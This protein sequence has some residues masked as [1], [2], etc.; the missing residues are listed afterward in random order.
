LETIKKI[1]YLSQPIITLVSG[2]LILAFSFILLR[3]WFSV[4]LV[5][6]SEF[7][8]NGIGMDLSKYCNMQIEFSNYFSGWRNSGDIPL[9]IIF[10]GSTFLFI[11]R[12]REKEQLSMLPLEFGVLNILFLALGTALFICGLIV[13]LFVSTGIGLVSG[14][15]GFLLLGCKT[16]AGF[17]PGLIASI[18]TTAGLFVSQANGWLGRLLIRL[19]PQYLKY[20]PLDKAENKEET[21]H[22]QVI[23]GGGMFLLLASILLLYTWL[24]LFFV[25]ATSRGGSICWGTSCEQAAWQDGLSRSLGHSFSYSSVPYMPFLLIF[26]ITLIIFMIR[27]RKMNSRSFLALEFGMLN[28]LWMLAGMA[29]FTLTYT[30]YK[31]ATPAPQYPITIPLITPDENPAY[32]SDTT[33]AEIPYLV[34][35]APPAP[36]SG[37]CVIADETGWSVFD[38]ADRRCLIASQIPSWVYGK[39]L[40]WSGLLASI[41]LVTGLSI[42]QATGWLNRWIRRWPDMLRYVILITAI[43]LAFVALLTEYQIFGFN[44]VVW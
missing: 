32:G 6:M 39:Q 7:P 30:G 24:N 44:L 34:L 1:K 43:G 13:G 11:F 37:A 18:L 31:A 23:T 29:V 9:L 3:L 14:S 17:W 25:N 26:H 42:S 15:D 36:P 4:F 19:F 35:T 28:I 40:A 5:F 12:S 8:V 27:Y 21:R 38:P 33:A 22:A 10:H 16:T 20:F 2:V 41:L